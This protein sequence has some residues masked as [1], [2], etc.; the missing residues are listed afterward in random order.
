MR[1]GTKSV[2][3]GAHCLLIHPFFVARGWSK[4]YGFPWA[5]SLWF[6]FGL[7]DI[8]Y[9]G[10]NDMDGLEGEDHVLMGGRIMGWLFGERW[11]DFTVR[12][13]RF[14]ARN[15]GVPVSKLCYADKL[16]FAMTPAWL[17]LPMAR[18]TGELAEYMQKSRDRQAGGSCFTDAERA[19][20]ESENPAVWLEG[21]Q[22]YTRRW[23][24]EHQQG[25]VDVWA[26]PDNAAG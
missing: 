3:F 12:H 10:L 22:Q 4:L 14:W 24:E 13:S 11:A 9:F 19:Q 2:L 8:G 1:V 25:G 23:V 20:I 21:L 26:V 17:Y 16:A 15:H 18:A 6:A 7:H 5:P